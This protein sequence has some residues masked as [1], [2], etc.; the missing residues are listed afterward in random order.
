MATRYFLGLDG[1]S[2]GKSG[3]LV[4]FLDEALTFSSEK[5]AEAELAALGCENDPRGYSQN[6]PNTGYVAE[7]ET[8]RVV[9]PT[10]PSGKAVK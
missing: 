7:C 5:E 2:W 4:D 1:A 6:G 8:G 10:K 9:W 3:K